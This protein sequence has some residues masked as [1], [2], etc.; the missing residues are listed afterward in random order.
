MIDWANIFKGLGSGAGP[1]ADPSGWGASITTGSGKQGLDALM[2]PLVRD[3]SSGAVT[4]LSDPF[5]KTLGGAFQAAGSAM[6]GGA[7]MQAKSEQAPQAPQ[8]RVMGVPQA[9]GAFQAPGPA[10]WLNPYLK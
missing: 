3:A 9:P 8:P 7:P 2:N 4:G 6:P 1:S 5:M 10:S